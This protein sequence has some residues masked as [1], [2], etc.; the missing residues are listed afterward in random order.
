MSKNFDKIIV[1]VFTL[2]SWERS[3]DIG[4]SKA[5]AESSTSDHWPRWLHVLMALGKP[6]L[7][8]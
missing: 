8:E 1:I 3:L 2:A 4:F 5:Q 6:A 7:E